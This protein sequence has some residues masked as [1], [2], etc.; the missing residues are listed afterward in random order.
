[1]GNGFSQTF[2]LEGG[3]VVEA[4]RTGSVMLEVRKEEGEMDRRE[5]EGKERSQQEMKKDKK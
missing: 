2:Y 3:W 1:M 5:E 4:E